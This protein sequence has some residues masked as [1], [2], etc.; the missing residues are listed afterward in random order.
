MIR[1]TI[2]VL[3]T[4]I[5]TLAVMMGVCVAQDTSTVIIGGTGPTPHL[6]TVIDGVTDALSSHGVK[7][8]VNS[9]DSKSRSIILDE[10]KTSGNTNLLYL[11]VN[12]V[13]GQR[14]KIS[15]ESFVDGK[16]VWE[17]ETRGSFMAVSAEGEVQ[18][19]LKS[20]IEKIEK[21]IGKE[22]LPK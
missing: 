11:T 7:V 5:A 3:G 6:Q 15:A 13:K 16:K 2:R 10:M 19:M 22:G 17:E 4:S 9:S 14:G 12:Q 18:G 20:I 1:T 8:K 21:H